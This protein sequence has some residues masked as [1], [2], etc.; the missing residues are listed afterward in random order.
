MCLTTL[1][2]YNRD[3]SAKSKR[4]NVTRDTGCGENLEVVNR[5]LQECCM[6]HRRIEGPSKV[7]S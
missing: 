4:R 3:K 1:H 2:V 6:C 7:H 5:Q